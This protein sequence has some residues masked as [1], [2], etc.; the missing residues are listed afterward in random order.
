M[1]RVVF[2]IWISICFGQLSFAEG[3]MQTEDGKKRVITTHDLGW[4]NNL[5]EAKA[6]ALKEKRPIIL[7]L[8]SQRCFYCPIMVEKVFPDP[9]V[10]K[11]LNENF[12]KLDLDV[13]TDSDSIEEGTANQAPERFIVSMTPAIVFMGPKEEKLYRKGKK[14]MII[15]GFWKPEELIRWGKEAMKRFDK[16][17]GEKYAK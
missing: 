6:M 17:Y 11:F 8:H 9:K 15:Y 4:M 5:E 14:H 13:A 1:L 3:T 10:Q 16:L 2:M 12:I 7:Y